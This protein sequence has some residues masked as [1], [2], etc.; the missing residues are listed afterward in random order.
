MIHRIDLT[1]AIEA[2]FVRYFAQMLP[3]L[4]HP[5]AALAML[6]KLE[7]RLHIVALSALH[8]RLHLPFPG[9]LFEMKLLQHRLRIEAV[10]VARPAFHHEKDAVL[11]FGRDHL[12]FRR[13]RTF[14]LSGEKGGQSHAPD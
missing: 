4:A 3:W 5:R 11:R 13:E 7:R 14:L 10:D 1:T 8:R 9:E 2:K 12:W 6:R